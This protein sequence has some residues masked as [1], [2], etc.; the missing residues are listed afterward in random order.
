MN[1]YSYTGGDPVNNVDKAGLQW[2]LIGCEQFINIGEGQPW[3]VCAYRWF[4]SSLNL[5]STAAFFR[6]SLF[7]PTGIQVAQHHLSTISEGN[8]RAKDKCREFFSKLIEQSK[9]DMS[10][11]SLMDQLQSTAAEAGNYVY[12]GPSSTT[13]IDSE[14]FP[15]VDT[16]SY[17]TLGAYFNAPE[18]N[19]KVE[20]L[21]Q[22]SGA[23]IWIRQANWMPSWS[24]FWD[25]YGDAY[26]LGTLAHELFHKK[27][28]G[29]GFT[30][31][32]IKGALIGVNALTTVPYKNEISVSLANICFSD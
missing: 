23:A 16:S 19:P 25:T 6:P 20:A 18:N 30:H 5:G 17:A 29:G 3:S 11:D 24:G 8:F 4:S 31:E 13:Q 14:K 7:V 10:V 9:L 21:S 12:D 28:V 26:G 1:Q 27:S 32:Q 2:E 22:K 15:G